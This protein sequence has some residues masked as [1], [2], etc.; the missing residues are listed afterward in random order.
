MY[1]ACLL[2]AQCVHTLQVVPGMFD[3]HFRQASLTRAIDSRSMLYIMMASPLRE[4]GREERLRAFVESNRPEYIY[5]FSPYFA[6]LAKYRHHGG[7]RDDRAFFDDLRRGA[8]PYRLVERIK[9]PFAF[10][11]LTP[12]PELKDPAYYLFR[13]NALRP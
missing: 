10:A 1:A 2:A 9:V 11:F 6:N 3:T 13:R 5:L 4:S 7:Y 12:D 8:L